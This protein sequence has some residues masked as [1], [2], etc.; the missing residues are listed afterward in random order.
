MRQRFI[1]FISTLLAVVTVGTIVLNFNES[2]V[3]AVALNQANLSYTHYS[4]EG[5]SV[6]TAANGRPK[7][8]VYMQ[9]SCWNCR[10]V[11]SDIL[12]NEALYTQIETVV[13][14]VNGMEAIRDYRADFSNYSN[15]TW[16]YGG[17]QAMFQYN[18]FISSENSLTT[19]L[20]VFIDSTNTIKEITTDYIDVVSVC[21]T[22]FN[23]EL[24][25]QGF[26]SVVNDS[27]VSADASGRPKLLMLIRENCVNCSHVLTTLL[28]SAELCNEV[29]VVA[30]Y[31]GNKSNALQIRN[32]YSNYDRITWCY[33]GLNAMQ[34][35]TD[36]SSVTTPLCVYIGADNVIQ[37]VT[38]GDVD[39]IKECNS[40]FG[41][42]IISSARDDG[43]AFCEHYGYDYIEGEPSLIIFA[44]DSCY[45]CDLVVKETL[46][47]SE[48]TSGVN[49]SIAFSGSSEDAADYRDSFINNSAVSWFG[50]ADA[51][52]FYIATEYDSS[53]QVYPV[54]V[55]IDKAGKIK[56]VTYGYV[57]VVQEFDDC[58]NL[59]FGD[60]CRITAS[61]TPTVINTP[62][63]APTSTPTSTVRPTATPTS[64]P[65]A[66]AA[67]VPTKKAELSVGDFVSRCYEV[68]LG[69]E[70]DAAGFDS[71]VDQLNN[72]QAC[73]AQVGY[74]FIFS[75]E[76]MNKATSDAR[77]V[78]DLYAMY[79]GREAD[80]AGFN[81]WVEQLENNISREDVFAGF[82]NSA[83]FN[84]LCVKYGVVSGVYI[85]GVPNSQQGGVNCF[86]ARLYKVCLNRLPDQGGQ[87]GWVMKLMHGEA[88]GSSAAYGFIFST[89]FIN[90]GLSNSDYV[91]Y[92]YRAFFGREADSD[93]LNY[94]VGKLDAGTAGREDVFSGFS[95]SAEF[96]NL[97]ASYGIAK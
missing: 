20:C 71:W 91:K 4:V 56:S 1:R 12:K 26:K 43:K 94:W 81:Y 86:V 28:N 23:L 72:G 30:V 74:G 34:K 52:L 92:M 75:G 46:S 27:L 87:A 80:E 79:F 48:L 18:K 77:F 44:A 65:I 45:N 40:R 63:V 41:L 39:I 22:V 83:E 57:N 67:P 33:D 70:P 11:I 78:K 76:Y 60:D 9:E 31:Y 17:K 64:T 73:G 59:C 58:C 6:S 68:A 19:P 32:Q 82:A 95:G 62:S 24:K 85:P 35:Y 8:L 90:M 25:P 36:K 53:N 88:T 51:S 84:N 16:C 61:P 47:N 97:C 55:F 38:E 21:S 93:G 69:R 42:S 14:S 49:V 13:V 66:T 10:Q 15:I 50:N 29:D 89:E 5:N 3:N 54:C 2:K 7:L 37:G 96:A